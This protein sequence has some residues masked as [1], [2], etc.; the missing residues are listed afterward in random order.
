MGES[1]VVSP[2]DPI[3]FDLMAQDTIALIKHLGIKRFNLL[4]WSLGGFIAI[5]VASNLPLDLELEKLII[6]ACQVQSLV[7]SY[8]ECL[9]NLP[10]PPDG[11]KNIQEQKDKFMGYCESFIDYM[12][13]HPDIFDK[14]AEIHVTANR[15]FEIFKRQWEAMKKAN[16]LSKSK[17]IKV[18]T[19][20]IHGEDDELVPIENSELLA[21]EITNSK[22]ISIPKAGHEEDYWCTIH[23]L[24]LDINLYLQE[25]QESENLVYCFHKGD[26][27]IGNSP[28][29]FFDHLSLAD[30]W[31]LVDSILTPEDVEAKT[32]IALSP[33]SIR[34]EEFQEFNK[35]I[36]KRFCMS[37]WSFNELLICQEHIFPVVPVDIMVELYSKAG[38]VPRYVL[39]RAEESIKYSNPNTLEGREKI[40][41]YSLSRNFRN[42]KLCWHFESINISNRLIH[43]WPN[44]SYDDYYLGWASSFIFEKIRKNWS[45]CL[46]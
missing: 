34:R 27:N 22:F 37:P 16:I 42:Q 36:V 7:P 33:Q 32:V 45:Q 1:S 9:Y 23:H 8:W 28:E 4:G 3:S 12:V 6:C 20:L 26:V 40:V 44:V 25:H 11:P 15:P 24:P 38:G 2:Y 39:Q 21:R 14:Y 31:Y 46:E 13:K 29:D 41:K 5:H 17:T 30:M 19:L 18:P 10:K 35:I 43:R